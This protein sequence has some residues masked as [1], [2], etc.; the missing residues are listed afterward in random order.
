M[1]NHI[2]VG[3]AGV[4]AVIIGILVFLHGG[5]SVP[6][7]SSSATTKNQ[8]AAVIVPF[9]K[10]I[11]GVQSSVDTRTN[12]LITSTK[13]LSELW[14]MIDAREQMPS[15][16]FTKDVIVAV[17]AGQKPTGGY[18]ITVSNIEDTDVRTVSVMLS[19][20]DGNCSERRAATAPYELVAVPST[21]LAFA[22]KDQATTTPCT[23]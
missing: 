10:L 4:V 6:N 9:T 14:K 22:H 11:Q 1:R 2:I 23:R 20:P 8:L 3:G 15:V 21:S 18:A 5:G 12:Y 17:F 16:D 19:L 13:Q 7:T